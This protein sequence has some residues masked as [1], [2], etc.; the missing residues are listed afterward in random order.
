MG[1][2]GRA[3]VEKH[4]DINKLNDD[5][6]AIYQQVLNLDNSPQ[7]PQTQTANYLPT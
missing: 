3:Y 6:V 1:K 4:F 2:A 5:L 7:Q